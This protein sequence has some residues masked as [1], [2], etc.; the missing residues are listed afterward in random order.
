MP[1]RSARMILPTALKIAIVAAAVTFTA[2]LLPASQDHPQAAGDLSTAANSELSGHAPRPPRPKPR[3]DSG[4]SSGYVWSAGE[5]DPTWQEQLRDMTRDQSAERAQRKV[6]PPE[7][8]AVSRCYRDF[9]RDHPG[10]NADVACFP[11]ER[12]MQG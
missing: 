5:T 3:P 1:E 7:E 9:E 8:S 6:E 10:E 11:N 4:G 12:W 2:A